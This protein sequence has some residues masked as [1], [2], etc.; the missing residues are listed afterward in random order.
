MSL[1]SSC[2]SLLSRRKLTQLPSS[3]DLESLTSTSSLPLPPERLSPSP[4]SL[5]SKSAVDPPRIRNSLRLPHTNISYHTS[6]HLCG[7]APFIH[8]SRAGPLNRQR[9]HISLASSFLHFTIIAPI[10]SFCLSHLR[11]R[12]PRITNDPHIRHLRTIL[13]LFDIPP[14]IFLLITISLSFDGL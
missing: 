8:A 14:S 13:Q 6:C 5:P 7:S 1:S 12:L 10:P 3:T 2:L 11:P 9:Y 4:L